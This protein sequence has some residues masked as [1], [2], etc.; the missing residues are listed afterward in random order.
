[1][2]ESELASVLKVTAEK[3]NVQEMITLD[4]WKQIWIKTAKRI[5]TDKAEATRAAAVQ[6][7]GD[8]SNFLTDVVKFNCVIPTARL[9]NPAMLAVAEAQVA[10]MLCIV[11]S[12]RYLFR[13][14]RSVFTNLAQANQNI[15][16]GY[17]VKLINVLAQG[18]FYEFCRHAI[19]K[20]CENRRD[21]VF[22]AAEDGG[23]TTTLVRSVFT[24]VCFCVKTWNKNACDPDNHP[25]VHLVRQLKGMTL[26]EFGGRYKLYV[27]GK[28]DRRKETSIMS[29][30]CYNWLDLSK[31]LP[32]LPPQSQFKSLDDRE[33][34]SVQLESGEYPWQPSVVLQN[35]NYPWNRT[36]DA[37]EIHKLPKEWSLSE[38]AKIVSEMRKIQD[39]VA[40]NPL[41]EIYM[42]FVVFSRVC[43]YILMPQKKRHVLEPDAVA[44]DSAKYSA[45]FQSFMVR[46]VTVVRFELAYWNWIGASNLHWSFKSSCMENRGSVVMADERLVLGNVHLIQEYENEAIDFRLTKLQSDEWTSTLIGILREIKKRSAYRDVLKESV[47]AV[48]PGYLVS[49]GDIELHYRTASKI[50]SRRP[51]DILN[52]FRPSEYRSLLNLIFSPYSTLHCVAYGSASMLKSKL[53]LDEMSSDP[54]ES[55]DPLVPTHL[56]YSVYHKMYPCLH[57]HVDLMQKMA[58]MQADSVNIRQLGNFTMS[59]G[60]GNE[61][62]LHV[63]DIGKDVIETVW[64]SVLDSSNTREDSSAFSVSNLTNSM[65]NL[66]Q[67]KLEEKSARASSENNGNSAQ[68]RQYLS[69]YCIR[70]YGIPSEIESGSFHKVL[71]GGMPPQSFSSFFYWPRKMKQTVLNENGHTK[72]KVPYLFGVRGEY[73]VGTP[74]LFFGATRCYE[75]AL[76]WYA[77]LCHKVGGPALKHPDTISQAVFLRTVTK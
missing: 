53:V 22:G 77:I 33:I 44:S 54:I 16:A 46:N 36:I 63:A 71:R 57:A 51:L 18:P 15:H 24:I 43:A 72:V 20:W 38:V 41:L 37:E 26:S 48:C 10:E 35:A 1:M 73:W 2:E 27:D 45:K 52:Y 67:K 47:G 59:F 8:V 75:Q 25:L 39:D 34:A 64:N 29:L 49:P 4:R 40:W 23:W 65:E 17:L 42:L 50:A 69:H 11:A 68:S 60:T 61:K 19:L 66:F 76:K 32:L 28:A 21:D 5:Q 70:S 31:G 74:G 7:I 12:L 56:K 62:V 14:A 6:I 58:R 30:H 55:I 9:L 13:K 3:Y